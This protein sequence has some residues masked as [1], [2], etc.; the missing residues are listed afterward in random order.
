[1]EETIKKLFAPGKGILAADESTHTIEK[2]FATLGLTSTPELNKKYRE[3]LFNTSGIEN[4]L[5]G[6]ILFDESVRQNL[7]NILQ[8]KDIVPGIKVDG[9]L[10]SFNGSEEQITKGLD[11]LD[12][13]LKEY[14][15]LGLKFTKWRAAVRIS[16]IFPTD[17]FLEEDLNRMAQFAKISQITGFT[18]IVEPEVQLDG[19]H[20]TTR[21]AEVSVKVCRIL[22]E[23][24]NIAGIDLKNLILKTNM[25]LPGKDSGV[26][27]APLEVAEVT[28]RSLKQSVPPEVGGIVF[29]SGGQTPDEATNNLNE[30]VKRRGDCPWPLSFS[31][32]RALQ[33]ETMRQW[34]GKDENIEYAQNTFLDRLIKVSKAR[35]GEL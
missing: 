19:N 22:F 24:L 27:A 29:L 9:G 33:E 6:V 13:R 21:C 25:V 23:K 20:T 7:H 12:T 31:F 26:K 18:P 11:G 8:E 10:E 17:A 35:K 16:D 34:S 15:V 4:Y 14:S 30:I 28:L 5:G 1:M 32:S 3:M 2:R